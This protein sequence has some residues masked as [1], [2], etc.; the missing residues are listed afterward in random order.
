MR[1]LYEDAD[2]IEKLAPK[3]EPTI[4]NIFDFDGTLF[5]S[6]NPNPKLWQNKTLG[7]LKASFDQGG[8]GWYQNVLTLDEKYIEGHD[9]NEDVVADAKKSIANPHAVTVMLTGR[10][11]A[12]EKVVNKLLT[13]KGL[14][15]DFTKF[16]PSD[17][18]ETTMEFK[19]RVIN[20]LL[21]QHPEVNE[22][23]MWEDRP[24]HVATF[25]KF[26]DGKNIKYKVNFID[27]PDAYIGYSNK[28]IEL[29]DKLKKDK[30]V[31]SLNENVST[32]VP[33][34]VGV[35]LD[36]QSQQKLLND[37]SDIIPNDWR[38]IAH[39]MTI[40]TGNKPDNLSQFIEDN[41]GQT[42]ALTATDIGISNDA[43][44]VKV[45]TDV[46]TKNAI[47]HITIAVPPNGKPV[48][49]NYITNWK[50]LESPIQLSGN[51]STKY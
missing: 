25:E 7:K 48:N 44:A 10:S 20:E 42:F 40:K 14:D 36:K 11:D 47:P 45:S 18:S 5:D 33:L 2:K 46:P 34:Y 24:K 13:D 39:H 4:L 28:E 43:I 37:L 6:P 9:F 23:N 35:M 50:P 17:T 1:N 26:L 29:V 22:V 41:M 8:Y 31:K 19:K 12:F 15:F 16:K 3:D 27:L 38:K 21:E 49:S 30:R 51:I 32:P